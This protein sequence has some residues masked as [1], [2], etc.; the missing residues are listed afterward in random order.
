MTHIVLPQMIERGA[1]AIVNISA[2]G[3][4][5]PTPQ[6]TV[7]TAT[8][9]ISYCISLWL[10]SCTLLY[11]YMNSIYLRVLQGLVLTFK[12]IE[13]AILNFVINRIGFRS[14]QLLL[15]IHN[16]LLQSYLAHYESF[17]LIFIRS[18]LLIEVYQSCLRVSV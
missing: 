16:L 7:Y 12:K 13:I 5:R 8:K 9:V 10:C 4:A 2:G 17:F 6:L 14:S 11:H 1:G 18:C 15:I 3:C